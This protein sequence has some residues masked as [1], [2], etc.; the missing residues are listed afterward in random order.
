MSDSR[1]KRFPRVRVILA[2]FLIILISLLA[3]NLRNSNDDSQA[4]AIRKQGYPATLVELDNW[5]RKIPDNENAALI[6]TNAFAKIALASNAFDQIREDSWIPK[7]GQP[8]AP[9]DKAELTAIFATN[10]EVL[11]LLYSAA[12]LTNSR[13]PLDLGQGFNSLLPHLAPI[14]GAIAVLTSEAILHVSDGE[15]PQA[16]DAFVAARRLTDSISQEPVLISQLVHVAGWKIICKRLEWTLNAANLTPE[17]LELLQKMLADA[18]EGAFYRGLVGEQATG[19]A[20]F[21]DP[22]W[23]QALFFDFNSAAANKP[24][25]S[26]QFKT[27]LLIGLLKTSGF[28][29]KDKAFY[30]HAMSNNVAITRLPVC[31]RFTASQNS[32]APLPPSKFYILSSML[33]PALGKAASRDADRTANVRVAE[34]AVAVERYRRANSNTVPDDLMQLVPAWIPAIPCDPF[35]GK[36]LRFKK[37]PQGYIVYSVG[38]DQQ[39]DGGTEYDRNNRNA[40]SDVTFILEH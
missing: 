34:T 39:D 22:K 5:Y 32:P 6:Y 20:V 13:Y 40:R 35:D 23:Q 28:F 36:P 2:V 25:R 33:L 14:K 8:I 9:E 10:R 37:R 27:Q 11:Q 19:C 31:E 21:H 7:R 4:E 17:Q 3:W 12:G 30:L 26:G 16:I 18:E 1:P 24:D 15:I 38:S 29:K